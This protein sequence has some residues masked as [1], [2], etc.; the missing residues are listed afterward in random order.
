M[1]NQTNHQAKEHY[2]DYLSDELRDKEVELDKMRR[3]NNHANASKSS[4]VSRD[5]D[6]RIEEYLFEL[7]CLFT[8]HNL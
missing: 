3:S 6:D 5:R 2:A 7:D 8:R 1:I 4:Q